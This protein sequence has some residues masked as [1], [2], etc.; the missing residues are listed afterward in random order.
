M[1]TESVLNASGLEIELQGTA[2]FARN[3]PSVGRICRGDQ[4]ALHQIVD[5]TLMLS[6]PLPG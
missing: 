3:P 4:I 5:G 6:S 1:A 2:H